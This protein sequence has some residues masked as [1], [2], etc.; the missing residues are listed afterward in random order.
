MAMPRHI[1]GLVRE[2]VARG[3]SVLFLERDVPWYAASR[4]LPVPPYGRTVLYTSLEELQDRFTSAVQGADVV[5]V[6][7]Y[8]PEGVAVGEWV[9]QTAS[10]VTAFYDIDTPITLANLH[11]GCEYLTTALIPRYALYLSFTGGLLIRPSTILKIVTY[12]MTWVLW[13]PTVPTGSQRSSACSSNRHN[14]GSRGVL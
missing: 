6:G 11:H 8:V 13:A 14:A 5:I 7:S 10:G 9:T 4:D 2:L 1:A 3:H 12:S